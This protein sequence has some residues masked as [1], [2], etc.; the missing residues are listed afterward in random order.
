[1]ELAEFFATIRKWL[2]LPILLGVTAGASAAA[3]TLRLT[4]IYEAKTT[5]LVRPA[6]TT[7]QAP[8]FLTLDQSAKTNAQLMTKRPLLQQVINDLDLPYATDQLE[9]AVSVT[10]ERDTQLLDVKTQDPNPRRAADIAN[11]LVKDFIAQNQK[12]AQQQISASLKNLETR[13]K[14][15]EQQ[16]TT[17][18]RAI[19][20]LEA[21]RK[22]TPDQQAELSALRQKE[23][24]DSATY[25]SL[26]KSYEEARSSQLARY[27]TLTVVESAAQPQ[28]PIGPKKTLNTLMAA[29]LGVMLA[30]GLAFL[31][32]YLDNTFKSEEDVRRFLNVPVLGNLVFARSGRQPESELTTLR[33]PRA[34]ASEAFRELRTNLLFSGVDRSLQTVVVTSAAPR[35]GK[36]RTAANL[37]ITL[38]Q[39]GKKCIL[40]DAD[41]R[42]PDIH[43]LFRRV[44][45]RG[46]SNMILDD[47]VHPEFIHQTELPTLQLICS[48]NLPPNPSELLG[49][50]RMLRLIHELSTEADVLVF[51]TPPLNAVTDAALLAARLDA[52]VLIVEAGRTPR[53]VVQRAKET[54]EKV[55]GSLV[56]VVLNKVKYGKEL[57][58]YDYSAPEE[59][60]GKRTGSVAAEGAPA[61]GA[62]KAKEAVGQR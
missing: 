13:I 56:G 33:H 47:R 57:Y 41:L 21:N 39:A 14:D 48:G 61:G 49:S 52:T 18:G 7:Q 59:P 45:Q 12:E 43:R 62:A 10:P 1:M 11:T 22:P 30:V 6:Q 23:A 2:W 26:V 32:E 29:A 31:L 15:L 37:A 28:R 60:K 36:S 20:V 25:A 38:A 27:D 5:V 42:R 4:P 50:Q 40:I 8:Y 16:I 54:I 53:P 46:L 55:G 34:P 3:I 44:D 17:S 58:Y 19:A 9:H 35:E 51:D 24:A